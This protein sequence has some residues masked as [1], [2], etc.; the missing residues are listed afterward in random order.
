MSSVT[1]LDTETGRRHVLSREAADRFTDNRCPFRFE[2]QP[3]TLR[4]FV[5]D[6]IDA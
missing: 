2:Q 3:K 5:T 4:E 1:F 6:E